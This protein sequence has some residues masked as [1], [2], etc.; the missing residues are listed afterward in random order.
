MKLLEKVA[1]LLLGRPVLYPDHEKTQA[2][3]VDRRVNEKWEQLRAEARGW[4]HQDSG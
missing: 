4:L 1:D 2:A 3:E